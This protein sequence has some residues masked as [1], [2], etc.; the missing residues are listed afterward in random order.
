[1]GITTTFLITLVLLLN[2]AFAQE[3]SRVIDIDLMTFCEGE[4][5]TSDNEVINL[6]KKITCDGI[7][8]LEA[9]RPEPFLIT[10]KDEEG[11][12]W[13]LR[14]HFGF[15]RTDYS[16]TD[17]RIKNDVINVV[18]KDVEMH[19]R[20]S[21]HHY[22]PANWDKF[23]N[24]F[25]WID[26]PTN[27]F[28]F[29]LEKNKN[30]FYLTIFHPKYLKS[31]TYSKSEVNGKPHYDFSE[32][33]QE[34]TDF[35]SP[36]PEGSNLLYLGNTHQNMIWQIGYGLQFT[37]FNTPKAGKLNYTIKGDVGLNTGKAR[38]VHIVPGVAWD[39][40]IDD[41]KIQGINASL[42]HRLEYQRGKVSL[43][44]DQKTIYSRIQ[45]GFYDGTIDYN[46]RSTPTTFGVGVDLFTKK[47]KK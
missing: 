40:Y 46:L 34:T 27:T 41:S 35:S 24:S 31:L 42:G 25:Q 22:N 8:K 19:E 32:V 26:E 39:D 36:I 44:L 30:V 18:I 14:F 6:E 3:E 5:S 16:K 4:Q 9:Q 15:S 29:S 33:D 47:K 43:F 23:E 21:A 28:T 1:M 20:T 45:H 7:K 12:T 13:K 11:N 2:C 38:S 37:L 10:K 17:L